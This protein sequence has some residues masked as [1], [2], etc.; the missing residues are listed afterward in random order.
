M[1]IFHRP[2]IQSQCLPLNRT[3]NL[4]MTEPTGTRTGFPSQVKGG[5]PEDRKPLSV[6]SELQPHSAMIS[7]SPF[8]H[9]SPN[10]SRAPASSRYDLLVAENFL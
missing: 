2:W 6:A 9:R 4:A 8:Q 10:A 1:L 5:V 7:I 3:E